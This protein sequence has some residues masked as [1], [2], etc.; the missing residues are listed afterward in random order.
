MM[1]RVLENGRGSIIA[2]GGL[3]FGNNSPL[4]KSNL[5]FSRIKVEYSF[6]LSFEGSGTSFSRLCILM[7]S[8]GIALMM[9]CAVGNGNGSGVASGVITELY[10]GYNNAFSLSNRVMSFTN[11]TNSLFCAAGCG[12]ALIRSFTEIPSG[13]MAFL[14][15]WADGKGIGRGGPLMAG[16]TGDAARDDG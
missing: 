8:G 9:S 13:G 14:I 10:F 6:L 1:A 12:T 4:P 2:G 16:G 5:E 3:H 11:A 7:P 15:S